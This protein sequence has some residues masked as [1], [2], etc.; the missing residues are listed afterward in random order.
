MSKLKSIHI[1]NYRIH[2]DTIIFDNTNETDPAKHKEIGNLLALVGKND[3]GKSS[4][5]DALDVFFQTKAIDV[6]DYNSESC[7]EISIECKLDNEIKTHTSKLVDG[8]IN[9]NTVDDYSYTEFLN[10]KVGS[11][12][13]N[14]IKDLTINQLIEECHKDTFYF[15][16]NNFRYRESKIRFK[17][18]F[19]V[20]RAIKAL[21]P[22]IENSTPEVKKLFD[23]FAI[24][25]NIYPILINKDRVKEQMQNNPANGSLSKSL[26]FFFSVLSFYDVRAIV[27]KIKLNSVQELIQD[28]LQTGNIETLKKICDIKYMFEE[29]KENTHYIADLKREIGLSF[30]HENGHLNGTLDLNDHFNEFRVGQY[31]INELFYLSDTISLYEI[32]DDF[33]QAEKTFWDKFENHYADEYKKDW[34]LQFESI[35]NTFQTNSQA[36]TIGKR[37]SGVRRLCSLYYELCKR[38]PF[39]SPNNYIFAIDEPEISLHP[40]QQRA[41]IKQLKAISNIVSDNTQVIISTHSPYIVNELEEENVCILKRKL[42]NNRK[43]LDDITDNALEEKLLRKNLLSEINYLAFEEASYDYHVALFGL[44]MN[45]INDKLGHCHLENIDKNFLKN[46]PYKSLTT[47]HT[48]FRTDKFEKLIVCKAT[49]TDPL[50]KYRN[51]IHSLPYCVRNY[52]DHPHDINSS[53]GDMNTVKTS[54]EQMTKIIKELKKLP[55]LT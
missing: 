33:L 45:L 8:V 43:E 39:N 47:F 13:E 27:N 49:E 17:K 35:L 14:N 54:I 6:L 30:Y 16:H 32:C 50:K 51:E 26:D 22:F 46:E 40:E 4:I 38:L 3:I 5:L 2:K 23:T 7:N 53:F 15:L 41:F 29:R 19:D 52:I 34:L 42:D 48:Y 36:I 1:K 25:H 21:M 31:K 9:N 28:F 55:N 37:G 44:L 12:A 24:D 11:D 10:I 20:M 18:M